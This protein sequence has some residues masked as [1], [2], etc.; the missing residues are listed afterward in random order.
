MTIDMS[1]TW[2][3]MGKREGLRPTP[4]PWVIHAHKFDVQTWHHNAPPPLCQISD[5]LTPILLEKIYCV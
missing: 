4:Y 2:A 1:H 5:S 3:L